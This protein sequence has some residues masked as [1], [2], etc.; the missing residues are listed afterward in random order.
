MLGGIF[1]TI[2]LAL[3]LIV[4]TGLIVPAYGQ[5]AAFSCGSAPSNIPVQEGQTIPELIDPQIASG[6]LCRGACG[7]DCPSTCTSQPDITICGDDLSGNCHYTWTYTGVISCGSSNFCRWHDACYDRLADEER[8]TDLNK[9]TECDQHCPGSIADCYSWMNGGGPYDSQLL[10]SNPPIRRGPFSGPCAETPETTMT[11]DAKPGGTD[12]AGNNPTRS[13]GDSDKVDVWVP[14]SFD[15]SPPKNVE[16]AKI[17]MVVKPIGQLIGT[18]QLVLKGVSGEGQMVYDKFSDLQANQWNTVEVDISGNS[19]VM[20]AIRKGHLEG[21]I[22]DDT[23]V[24][25]VKLLI[26]GTSQAIGGVVSSYISPDGKDMY[27]PTGV[28]MTIGP[29]Q[30]I[31]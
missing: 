7:A 10:F 6:S 23:A 24:Q 30:P 20:D 27:G 28:T 29:E 13:F 8:S 3:I 26:G 11:I 14:F 2:K 25:S 4:L 16:T 5:T 18:D 15:F 21:L 17:V 19:D 22:Q 9:F 31:A 12:L 1:V